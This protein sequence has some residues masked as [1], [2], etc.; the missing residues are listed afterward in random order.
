MSRQARTH[1]SFP[2]HNRL[3]SG[4]QFSESIQLNNVPVAPSTESGLCHNGINLL[5]EKKYFRFWSNLA[6]LSSRSN[7]IQLWKPNVQ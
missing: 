6:D 3:Y 4:E 5:A 2:K 7:P 1:K